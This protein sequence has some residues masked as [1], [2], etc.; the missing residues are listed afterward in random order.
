MILQITG[1]EAKYLMF[2]LR[3]DAETLSDGDFAEIDTAIELQFNRR[4][5]QKPIDLKA[6]K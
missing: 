1:A 5:Y 6:S 2:V 3:A 4:I